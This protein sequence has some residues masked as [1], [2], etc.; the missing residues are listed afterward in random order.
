MRAAMGTAGGV[1]VR[2][3]NTACNPGVN[4]NVWLVGNI[5]GA[6]GYHDT[7]YGTG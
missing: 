5:I 2:Y 1:V 7:G 3:C 4:A 6:D